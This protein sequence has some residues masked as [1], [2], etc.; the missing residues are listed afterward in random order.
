MEV[1]Y[2]W[3]IRREWFLT[4]RILK[5][6]YSV[7]FPESFNS[8]ASLSYI[9]PLLVCF[10]NLLKPIFLGQSGDPLLFFIGLISCSWFINKTKRTIRDFWK[11]SRWL[12]FLVKKHELNWWSW[13]PFHIKRPEFWCQ[14]Q[15]N[16]KNTNQQRSLLTQNVAR[17]NA[18]HLLWQENS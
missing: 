10:L 6:C 1:K 15:F 7:K 8:K 17:T 9:G 14:R 18:Y 16:N 13:H 5:I 4:Q 2:C 12:G 3:Q 11:Q